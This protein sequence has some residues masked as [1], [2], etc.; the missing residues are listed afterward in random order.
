MNGLERRQLPAGGKDLGLTEHGLGPDPYDGGR[1][2]GE[3][4][5]RFCQESRARKHLVS[6]RRGPRRTALELVEEDERVEPEPERRPAVRRNP[7]AKGNTGRA[8]EE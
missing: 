5:R 6:R 1:C 3:E 4:V 2:P 7:A 8:G